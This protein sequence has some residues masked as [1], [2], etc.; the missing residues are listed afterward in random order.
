M[1]THYLHFLRFFGYMK[2]VM[3]QHILNIVKRDLD[4]LHFL[5]HKIGNEVITLFEH[6]T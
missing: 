6:D 1:V 5:L 2:Y 4:Y 3:K